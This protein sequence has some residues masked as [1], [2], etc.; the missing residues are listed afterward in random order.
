[1]TSCKEFI[2]LKA[3][4]IN[5]LG[6]YVTVSNDKTTNLFLNTSLALLAFA[7]NSV[8]CRLALGEGLIDASGFTIIRLFSGAITLVILWVLINVRERKLNISSFYSFG[9]WKGALYLLV[10][11]V[12]FSFAYLTLDTGTGALILFAAVQITMILIGI[13]KGGRLSK[14]EWLGVIVAFIGFIYLVFPTLTTPSLKGFLLMTVSGIAWGLYS[15]HGKLSQ[16]PLEDT[17]GNFIRTVPILL[18]ILIVMLDRLALTYE[19]VLLAMASGIFASALGYALWYAVIPR[20]G[21]VMPAVLQL[22][23][24]VIAA[25]GGIVF[26][27]EQVS[28]HLLLSSLLIIGG[29]LVVLKAKAS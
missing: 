12:A 9:S 23:V 18:L 20:L 25:V 5:F 4:L 10:Y 6:I 8:F 1:M 29:I 26:V 17:L 11:A 7:G 14:G 21:G 3:S 28:L 19:G 2:Y 22:L 24:P 13:L 16:K 15:L 27:G